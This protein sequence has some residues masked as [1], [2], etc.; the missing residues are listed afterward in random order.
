MTETEFDDIF[1][2]LRERDLPYW[3]DP[4]YHDPQHINA[5]DDG[6]GVYFDD[7][8]HRLKSSPAPTAAA[9]PKPNTCTR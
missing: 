6:R 8:D 3:S 4:M 5:W 9:A 2:R 1:A 7:P